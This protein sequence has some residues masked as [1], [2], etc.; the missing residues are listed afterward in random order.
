MCFFKY[1][2][3]IVLYV[4]NETTWFGS[5]CSHPPYLCYCRQLNNID[6]KDLFFFSFLRKI[7]TNFYV[8]I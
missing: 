2:I 3:L 6:C 8:E 1:K 5:S 4:V 7:H